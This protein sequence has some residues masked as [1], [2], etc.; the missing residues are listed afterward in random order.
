MLLDVLLNGLSQ[1]GGIGASELVHLDGVLDEQERG[2]TGDVV[3]HGNVFAL[4]NI[5]LESKA[6]GLSWISFSGNVSNLYLD[7]NNL[8]GKLLRQLL[9]LGR[10]HLAG[11]TP[12]GKEVH[13]DQLIA[14]IR[15]LC[16]EVVLQMTEINIYFIVSHKSILIFPNVATHS[17]I[18]VYMCWLTITVLANAIY[19]ISYWLYSYFSC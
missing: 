19:I 3:F 7:Y 1:S 15:Q 12:G 16:L 14:R 17:Y 5:N 18:C 9:Q 10:N 2:H 11:S 6:H 4:I 8:F 13:N